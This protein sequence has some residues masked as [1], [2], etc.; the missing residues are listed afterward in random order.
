MN[1]AKHK[2]YLVRI[3]KDV[4]DDPELGTIL[5]FK[6]GTALLFFYA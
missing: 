5:G 2:S 1:L 3:L 6:G 4:Y